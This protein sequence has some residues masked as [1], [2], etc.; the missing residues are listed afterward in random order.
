MSVGYLIIRKVLAT[1]LVALLL[2][3]ATL[4]SAQQGSNDQGGYKIG[5]DDVLNIPP[6]GRTRHSAALSLCGV[7][8]K[9]LFPS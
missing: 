5:P 2:I 9:S 4:A 8:V 7:T 1:T 3:A 6:Y